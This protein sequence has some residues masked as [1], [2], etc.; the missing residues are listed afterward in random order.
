MYIKKIVLKNFKSFASATVLLDSGFVSFVGPNGSGKCV[1]GDAEIVLGDG[2]LVAAKEIVESQLAEAKEKVAMDDGVFCFNPNGVE[3]FSL[4]P[5]TL[6]MEKKR[7]QAFVKRTS[8]SELCEVVTRSGK[9]IVST[10]YHPV[11][12][13]VDGKLTAVESSKLR[14]GMRVAAADVTTPNNSFA[15]KTVVLSGLLWDEIK[16]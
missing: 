6:K 9:K 14:E 13:L 10:T 15:S 11:M 1:R 16:S 8:P 4:N 5:Q 12:T 7:V 3:V 2:S